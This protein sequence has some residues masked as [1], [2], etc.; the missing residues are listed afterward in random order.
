M[1]LFVTPS[2]RITAMLEELDYQR[3][4][5]RNSLRRGTNLLY[6]QPRQEMVIRLKRIEKV[7]NYYYIRRK[8]L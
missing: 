1:H 6:G 7:L 3:S 4:F 5:I 8:G 2:K